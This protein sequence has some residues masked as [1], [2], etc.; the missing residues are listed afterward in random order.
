MLDNFSFE[1]GISPGGNRKPH[2]H[3]HKIWRHPNFSGGKNQTTF[4]L[5]TYCTKA[6][7][8]FSRTLLPLP[9]HIFHPIA[10]SIHFLL[11]LPKFKRGETSLS[12]TGLRMTCLNCISLFSGMFWCAPYFHWEPEHTTHSKAAWAEFTRWA[13]IGG[14]GRHAAQVSGTSLS[15]LGTR[16]KRNSPIRVGTLPRPQVCRLTNSHSLSSKFLFVV[17]C[18]LLPSSP[19][20]SYSFLW[21]AKG[22][23]AIVPSLS[24]LHLV[25]TA[26]LTPM[27]LTNW[28]SNLFP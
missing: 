8:L 20:L 21:R 14:H 22:L 16:W 2:I 13:G 27:Y 1:R 12:K 24:F 15:G 4:F 26:I 19:E 6:G 23:P 10:S 9:P 7:T 18:D 11:L 28:P 5:G 25:K 3:T 17:L